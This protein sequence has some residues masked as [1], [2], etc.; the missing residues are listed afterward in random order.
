V[1]IAPGT[2]APR[3]SSGLEID[4]ILPIVNAPFRVY[5]AFNPLNVREYIQPPIVAERS[6]FP[7]E[8]TYGTYIATYGQSYPFFE[9]RGLFRFTIGRTF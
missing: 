8:A 7:N 3:M 9:R 5:Y 6:L 1:V 2:E 4:V